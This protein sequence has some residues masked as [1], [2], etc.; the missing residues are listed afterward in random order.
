VPGFNRV[1]LRER[2][3]LSHRLIYRVRDKTVSIVS[4][5]HGARQLRESDRLGHKREVVDD[6]RGSAWVFHHFNTEPAR[7]SVLETACFGPGKRR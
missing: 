7:I 5:W 6:V 3:V 2:L 1:N 4:V